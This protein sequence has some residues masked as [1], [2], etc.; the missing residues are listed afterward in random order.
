[1]NVF[2]QYL[3]LRESDRFGEKPTSQ[4][5][6]LGKLIRLAWDRYEPETK[7]FFSSLA[8]KDP[9]IKDEFNKLDK[10]PSHRGNYM[11]GH[12]EKEKDV[13]IPAAADSSSG[14]D[15]YE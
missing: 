1:M 8:D 14:S 13:I 15:E 5:D 7:D 11:T 12:Q 6:T 3:K 9:D 2:K 4:D 10:T